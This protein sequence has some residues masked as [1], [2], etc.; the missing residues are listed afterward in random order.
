[1]YH[2][3]PNF[4]A[5]I[6]RDR[7]RILVLIDNNNNDD[8]GDDDGDF[9]DDDDDDVTL[10]SRNKYFIIQYWCFRFFVSLGQSA[11]L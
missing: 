4:R 6:S 7:G 1:M 2:F 10:T 3:R 9:D 11:C 8:D 5:C